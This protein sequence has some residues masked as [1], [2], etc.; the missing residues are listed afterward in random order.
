MA[1]FDNREGSRLSSIL[2]IMKTLF[3][4]GVLAG[5]SICFSKDTTEMVL[6]PIESMIHKIK[7]ISKNPIEAMQNNERQEYLNAMLQH[8]QKNKK[9]CIIKKKKEAPLETVILE[10]TISKIGALLALGF[11]EA[12]SEIIAKNMTTNLSKRCLTHFRW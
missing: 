10:K 3:I 5:G 12:G 4:C 7:M 1:I 11:G 9:C 6:E 8:E 2:N